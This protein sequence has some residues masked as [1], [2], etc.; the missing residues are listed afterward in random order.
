MGLRLQLVL[1]LGVLLALAFFPLHATVST[2]VAYAVRDLRAEA[3]VALAEAAAAHLEEARL[4]GRSELTHVLRVQS[5]RDGVE[6][7]ALYDSA[8]RRMASA[9]LDS[10]Y[11]Q[12]PETL[13]M[14]ALGPEPA[15]EFMGSDT[16]DVVRVAIPVAG[17]AVV[18]LL[19]PEG[20]S[21]ATR[22]VVRLIGLYMGL[23]A[24]ALL[25]FT[26]FAMTRMIVRP[27]D[28]LTRA[29]E[30]VAGGARRL[31]VPD[32]APRE[33]SELGASLHHMTDT[34]LT[35]EQRLR[36]HVEELERR[37]AE[38]RQAQETLIRT[39]R[40]ASVG[41]L[42]AGLAHEIGNPLAALIGMQDLL[43]D[44]DLPTD[45]RRDFLQRM[46]RET[47]RIHGILGD[48][49]QFAR[50]S[51]GGAEAIAQGSIPDAVSDTMALL[52]P[53]KAL[54]NLSLQTE[55]A[56]DLPRVAISRE[57]LVQVLLNLL[58][59][60]ADA[61]GEG[62]TIKV[63]AEPAAA[64]VLLQVEDDGPG[65]PPEIRSRLFE[66]FV[67]SK[68]VGQGTGLGLA[69]C[70][71]LLESVGGTIAL[72]ESYADGARFLVTLPSAMV[73]ASPVDPAVSS[74]T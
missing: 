38:L 30:R 49:L 73:S 20:D 21:V 67:T 28:R 15:A 68:E 22:A 2:Y 41:R 59:N 8:G 27:L 52:A 36:E 65:V 45:E 48:L 3:S 4:T 25:V 58:L 74:E 5:D 1:L 6:A 12:L 39:E 33:L 31:E 23:V 44:G 35:K 64:G 50:P 42:S 19:H 7:I 18:A 9:G 43:I 29:A 55:L 54:R 13:N 60:A 11:N 32:R 62:A 37:G 51:D 56:P 26:Y 57:Q 53:Q 47:E 14:D 46:R 10:A 63:R 70:R 34:L 71:G 61:C 66:P 40:L 72:D 24:L 69:V 17:G 16:A